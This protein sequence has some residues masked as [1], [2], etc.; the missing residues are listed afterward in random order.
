[1]S[2]MI[3]GE[4]WLVDFDPSIGGEIQKQRPAVIIS[5]DSANQNLNRVVVIPLT[6][7]VAKLYPGEAYVMLNGQ[8]RKAMSDQLTTASKLRLLR[9]MG[10]LS[11]A[12]MTDVATAVKAHL[13]LT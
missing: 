11:A 6:S 3:R 9:R 12:D 4:V 1:M 7:N 2:P 10:Q 13:D 5:N 8:Q